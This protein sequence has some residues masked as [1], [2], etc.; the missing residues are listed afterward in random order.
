MAVCDEPLN[1]T[2]GGILLGILLARPDRG[3]WSANLSGLMFGF[4]AG[5]DHRLGPSRE[6]ESTL[7]DPAV[8]PNHIL[9]E[10]ERSANGLRVR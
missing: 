6:F 4:E 3:K 10:L 1:A 8:V 2:F 5:K 9:L 7:A